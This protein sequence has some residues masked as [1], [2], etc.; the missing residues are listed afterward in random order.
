[1][2]ERNADAPPE[3]R[4]ECRIGINVGDII[5]DDWAPDRVKNGESKNAK[6]VAR[7]AG[8]GARIRTWEWRNQN[9]STSLAKSIRFLKKIENSPRYQS[10]G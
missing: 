5:A 10:I 8:W 6:N 3:D 2:A 7:S 4:I 9:P 1:M